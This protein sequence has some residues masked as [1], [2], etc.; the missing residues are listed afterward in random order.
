MTPLNRLD[1]KQLHILSLL[2][3]RQNLSRVAEE[4]G[5][6]QQ[7]VSEQLR[8]MRHLFDDPLFVRESNG[9]VAT[10]LASGM[11]TDIDDILNRIDQL[12]TKE[13][14]DPASAR[15]VFTITATDYALQVV[16]PQL[17]K[18]IHQKAPELKLVVRALEIPALES[19]LKSGEIDL[20][21]SFPAMIPAQ[22]P[23]LRLFEERHCC[24]AARQSQLA[25]KTMSAKDF[26][27]YPQ[28]VVSPARANLR[29]SADA[30]FEKLGIQRNVVFSVPFFSS[31]ARCVA[32]TD[33]IA[34]LPSRMLPHPE[35]VEV[36][37]D[38]V[39]PTFEIVAAWHQRTSHSP[40][41]T[42]IRAELS[43]LFNE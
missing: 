21:I 5:L 23:T 24:V 16:L 8:K 12:L 27:E 2:I 3:K 10:P 15:G 29:G 28:V 31:V 11:A 43:S 4:I 20:A 22:L 36:A 42:W 26:G 9:M 6:T 34:L 13:A 41:H 19:L 17:F 30:F 32:T 40:L 33:S 39:T 18:N 37:T 7:A 35:L 25:K 38:F 1:I 14:F